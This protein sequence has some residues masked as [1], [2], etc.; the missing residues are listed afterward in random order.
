MGRSGKIDG[1]ALQVFERDDVEGRLM[2]RGKDDPRRIARLERLAPARSAQAPTVAWLEPGKPEVGLRRRQIVAA[3]LGEF[4]ELGSHLDADR[5]Q[6]E[7]LG[8]GMAAA[9][10]EKAG[11]RPLR[12]A[13]QRF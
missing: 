1:V 3:R 13:L 10:A 9:G 7:I 11:E 8:P 5:M 2:G 12:A 4:E 6:P